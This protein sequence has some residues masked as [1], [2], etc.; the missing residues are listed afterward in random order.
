MS[1]LIPPCDVI[2]FATTDGGAVCM[3]FAAY[4][5]DHN[6]TLYLSAGRGLVTVRTGPI[7]MIAVGTTFIAVYTGNAIEIYSPDGDRHMSIDRCVV[8]MRWCGS[9]RLAIYCLGRTILLEI[10]VKDRNSLISSVQEIDLNISQL[11]YMSDECSAATRQC[12]DQ[13]SVWY[14]NIV[15]SECEK[16]CG[17]K[18]DA[19]VS[20][21]GEGKLAI[22][23]GDQLTIRKADKILVQISDVMLATWGPNEYI[24]CTSRNKPA[25][26]R[27][28]DATD[29][30][31]FVIPENLDAYHAAWC[32]PVLLMLRTDKTTLSHN[33][34]TSQTKLYPGLA[35]C[36]SG[37][38]RIGTTIR[39]PTGC[40]SADDLISWGRGYTVWYNGDG[41]Y[42][43]E[44]H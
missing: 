10:R 18:K 37:C 9:C 21:S 33:I 14:V 42:R 2:E 32:G 43:V 34:L 8:W 35:I 29:G 40:V 15:N 41:M 17:V 36:H 6:D 11:Y 25:R 38:V 26:V 13:T 7:T 20:W 5:T 28:F 22:V 44:S 31:Q 3:P 27:L 30:S 1:A 16:V 23:S 39:T 12:G 24:A 19:S 4:H